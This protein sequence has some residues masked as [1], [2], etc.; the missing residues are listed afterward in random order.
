MSGARR[1]D[2]SG[3]LLDG[4]HSRRANKLMAIDDPTWALK[5]H[6]VVASALRVRGDATSRLLTGVCAWRAG[7]PGRA[8]AA[9]SGPKHQIAAF[10]HPFGGAR[11]RR[12]AMRTPAWLSRHR[13]CLRPPMLRSVE[14]AARR[15]K[16][17]GARAR[18][19]VLLR[20]RE[21]TARLHVRHASRGCRSSVDALL[22]CSVEAYGRGRLPI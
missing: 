22:V 12:R 13:T 5:L 7:G 14:S 16:P 11:R 21:H 4:L 1:A 8:R 10:S 2:L 6:V 15:G 20:A 3:V 17:G 18:G 19:S 9:R